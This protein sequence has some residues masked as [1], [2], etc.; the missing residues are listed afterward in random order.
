MSAFRNLGSQEINGSS[1][2]EFMK[3]NFVLEELTPQAKV[4]A[5]PTGLTG[6]LGN[7]QSEKPYVNLH[8]EPVN[9]ALFFT[10]F[11]SGTSSSPINGNTPQE[12]ACFSSK[13]AIPLPLYPLGFEKAPDTLTYFV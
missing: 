9:F 10:A 6:F 5:N 4:V 8:V 11:A 12:A 13:V 2:L 3:Q 1:D 7:E